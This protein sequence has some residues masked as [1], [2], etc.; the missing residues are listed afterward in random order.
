MIRRI[1][2][3]LPVAVPAAIIAVAGW[4]HR[5]MNEDAYIN[6]RVVEQIFAGHGPV[7]NAGERIEAATSPLWIVVLVIGR[8]LAG[9]AVRDEWVAVVASLLAA[10]LAFVVAGRAAARLHRDD[11]G[12]VVPVGLLL[13]AAVAVVWDFSTSGLEMGLVWLW[14]ACSWYALVAIARDDVEGGRR[15]AYAAL[16]G[17]APLIRPELTLMMLCFIA[18]W[19]TLLRPRRVVRDLVAMFAVPV[20]Y[21][22]FR[23]GYYASLVPN[24]ALAKDAGGLHIGQGWDYARDLI[25]AYH[26]WLTAL[27]VV[28]VLVVRHLSKRD[29]RV[30]VVTVAMLGAAALDAGYITAVGGD[31]M[32]GRLLL[33]ALFAAGLPASFVVRK[34][35]PR[36]VAVAGVAC[37][38]AAVSIVAF[39]PP[40]PPA[41][42]IVAPI[43]DWRAV[44]GGKVVLDDIQ[45]PGYSGHQ[46]AE[47][48]ADGQRGYYRVLSVDPLPGKD[49]NQLVFT[50]GS[51]GV[52]AYD[53][54][55][56]VWVVDIGG[57]AEPLAARTDVVPDRP[58]GHRK[59]VDFAWYDARFMAPGANDTVQVI[60]ARHVLEDCG[61]VKD[62]MEAVNGDLT[63]GRF[64]SNIWHSVEFTRLH[65]PADP[66]AAEQEFCH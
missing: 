15:V 56:R 60:A 52:P 39:R 43:A 10:V 23:M 41:G 40:P 26:L 11:D 61:P 35:S 53:A 24:T 27:I 51:I 18:T 8:A 16:L 47:L 30:T 9:W 6:L 34:A 64:L 7:F 57:L 63:V 45:Y 28:V 2:T 48:Y 42:F 12:L 13:V 33:P 14:L 62:L 66:I 50:L 19:F 58:A 32:H 3:A 5:W 37:V 49:P 22:I 21:E 25:D 17:L 31:Y 59:Q 38:W 44:S 54:G 65:I 4:S 46:V 55:R 20:A 36:D 1:S 29:R